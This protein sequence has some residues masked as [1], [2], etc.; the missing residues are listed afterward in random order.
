MGRFV[1]D[2]GALFGLDLFQMGAAL[3]FGNREKALKGES[4]AG[5]TRNGQRCHHGRAAWNGHHFH[6]VLCAQIH[7]IYAGIGDG[8]GTCIGDDGAAF[9]LQKA[10]QDIIALGAAIVLKIAHL[11]LF[12]FEFIQQLGTHTGVL[13]GDEVHRFQRFNGSGRKITQIADG[14]SYHIQFSRFDIAHVRTS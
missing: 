9:A 13:G 6:A 14:G 8:R 11:G 7:Q 3:L 1:K 12:D 4:A 5:H 10:A 2:H